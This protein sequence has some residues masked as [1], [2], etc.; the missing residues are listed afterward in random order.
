MTGQMD[1]SHNKTGKD[2][3]EE[4]EIEVNFRLD[5][6]GRT[7]NTK[8]D[9]DC[10]AEEAVAV[11]YEPATSMCELS[12]EN[13]N[14]IGHADQSHPL[15]D[16]LLY[17]CEIA[18]C[19][20]MPRTFWVPSQRFE[21]RCSLE[22]MALDIFN[23]HVGQINNFDPA[24]SGAEWWVQIRPS[25]E[26]TGRYSM[27][28][29][30]DDL[31]DMATE[32]I[33]FHWD[34]DEDLRILCG[35]TTYIHPHLSTV[36]YLT[37]IGA[38]TIAFN[39]HVNNMTGEYIMP[40]QDKNVEGFVSWPKFGKHMSFDGRYLHAAP[41]DLMENGAFQ[42]QIQLPKSEGTLSKE[43][44]IKL[45]RRH[46]RVT[47]LVNIW[48][49][50]KPLGVQP[51]PET[52]IDKLSG[53]RREQAKINLRFIQKKCSRST[54][55]KTTDPITSRHVKIQGKDAEDLQS[56][57]K[58]QAKKFKWPLGGCDSEELIEA[59][60]PLRFVREEAERGGSLQMAWQSS[61]DGFDGISLHLEHGNSSA[62]QKPLVS[63]SSS[64]SMETV[65]KRR[66]L[67]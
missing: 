31:N 52:M 10:T 53:H 12:A 38:P 47:F 37:S 40:G 44:I 28:D 23:Y 20:L 57:K 42:K 34:K 54:K 60:I 13:N 3:M 27:H 36:T 62:T 49:N 18:D 55:I 67:D 65:T 56:G 39:I 4:E 15:F 9:P 21:P 2:T 5:A 1:S 59:K 26:K 63:C 7:A 45:Q 61:S 6:E 24:T 50:Y 30:S 48:L 29:K 33:S 17:D 43:E 46:R 58:C 41:S 35:G 16:E 8:V 22:Q 51:F 66:R 64:H 14:E 11:Q 32:G 19:G 25:P